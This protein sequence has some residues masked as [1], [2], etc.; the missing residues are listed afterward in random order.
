MKFVLLLLAAA[1]F[2]A[3]QPSVDRAVQLATAG[4]LNEAE[5]MLTALEKAHPRDADLQYRLGLVL[6]K[7]GKLDEARRHLDLAAKLN[8]K[9]PLIWRALALLHN[10]AGKAAAAHNDAA[11]A[12][13]EF[14]EAIRRDPERAPYYLDLAQ[15]F[16]DRDTPEP[17]EIV[18]RNAS[19]RFPANVNVLRSF[20]LALYA[21]GKYDEALVVFLKA[22]DADP[23]LE[24]AYASLEVLL[25]Y[26]QPRLPEVVSRLRRFCERKPY[27]PIGPYLLGLVVPEES[28]AL[29]RKAIEAAP[30]F[31]PAYFELHKLLKGQGKWDEA[32][33]AL[34]KTIDLNGSYAPAHYA[35]AQYY[36]RKGDRD[37]AAQ[38]REIH[39]KLLNDQR[40]AAEKQ[41]ERAPRLAYTLEQ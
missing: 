36:D 29:F 8:P 3:D 35:L 32:A 28:E 12:V 31:W 38:E 27:S 5:A 20:G 14:Q 33:A 10:T 39:H 13:K 2:A 37:R 30:G 17:A 6:L 16:L 19:Q 18:L 23:D 41:R 4:K 21:L 7:H 9:S 24:E 1:A 26:A 25:P 15:L 34:Q 40:V 11:T 22:I